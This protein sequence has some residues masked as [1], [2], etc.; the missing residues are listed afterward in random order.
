M[1]K[2]LDYRD[3]ELIDLGAATEETHG[4]PPGHFPDAPQPRTPL[5]ILVD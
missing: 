3:D 4:G 2:E 1:D 5:G